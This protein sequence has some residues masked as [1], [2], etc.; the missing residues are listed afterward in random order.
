MSM[1]YNNLLLNLNNDNNNQQFNPIILNHL[2]SL[3]IDDK[4][5]IEDGKV[6]IMHFFQTLNI[7][8]FSNKNNFQILDWI[9]DSVFQSSL[10]FQVTSSFLTKL[11]YYD[12]SCLSSFINFFIQKVAPPAKEKFVYNE[13]FTWFLS[14]ISL[15]IEDENK[16]NNL[17][18]NS[19]FLENKE[20]FD[21][22]DIHYFLQKMIYEPSISDV[23]FYLIHFFNFKQLLLQISI[24]CKENNKRNS[25]A[26]K[27][28]FSKEGQIIEDSN[29]LS[30]QLDDSIFDEKYF[31]K[32]IELIEFNLNEDSLQE[33]F[34]NY[35]KN[36][37]GKN[38]VLYF[39][40]N[41]LK[42]N[43]VQI[44]LFS[45][46][47]EFTNELIEIIT[48]YKLLDENNKFNCN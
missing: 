31:S 29:N 10:L 30:I 32:I 48:S 22:F 12:T 33:F 14:L 40:Q 4:F 18:Q 23:S 1:F 36:S 47:Q 35:L 41:I 37:F 46:A 7:N 3:Y 28:T 27:I 16:K 8:Y 15:L 42:S 13:I 21:V 39:F 24:L 5:K 11:V 44:L 19:L 34:L 9:I 17:N 2:H 45:F 26:K 20:K 6:V 38:L 43:H 25:S